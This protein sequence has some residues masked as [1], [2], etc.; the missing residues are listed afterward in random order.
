MQVSIHFSVLNVSLVITRSIF[1]FER[2][3]NSGNLLRANDTRGFFSL[4]RFYAIE[5]AGATPVGLSR[6]S[7]GLATQVT[8]Q[9]P[10]PSGYFSSPCHF[11]M[12]HSPCRPMLYPLCEARRLERR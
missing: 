6:R 4:A 8:A 12:F 3:N 7:A 5:H 1:T 11:I 2:F 10:A 9:H